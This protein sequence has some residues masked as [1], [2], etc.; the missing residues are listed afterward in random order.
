MIAT[1]KCDPRKLPAPPK[2]AT[3]TNRQI[4][5]VTK[6]PK[7]QKPRKEEK[8]SSTQR[9]YTPAQQQVIYTM[10]KQG[11]SY[12]AISKEI[13]KSPNAIRKF[14]QKRWG[15]EVEVDRYQNRKGQHGD[16]GDQR[17]GAGADN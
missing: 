7:K 3:I 13:G 14:A 17:D 6:K 16:Q 2:Y 15:K 10:R 11:F 4:V 5:P 1:L 8:R 12:D 9:G